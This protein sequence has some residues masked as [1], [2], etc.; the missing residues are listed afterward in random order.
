ME[1]WPLTAR[2][3]LTAHDVTLLDLWDTQAVVLPLTQTP[4]GQHN[5]WSKV[6]GLVNAF[7]HSGARN[8]VIS[9]GPRPALALIDDVTYR[10]T[11]P[12]LEPA[13]YRGAGD[14]MT[15]G[16]AA[17][18][19]RGLRPED[20]LRL[21]SGAGAANAAD[22]TTDETSNTTILTTEVAPCE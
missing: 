18:M 3:K 5:G 6:S 12:D 10:V 21:A 22:T 16:L 4:A 13:D 9:R 14:S 11:G 19:R 7:V 1:L 17:G 8:V 20:L 15:A 2:D